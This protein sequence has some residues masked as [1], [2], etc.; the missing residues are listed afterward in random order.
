MELQ[1][2]VR[3]LIDFRKNSIPDLAKKSKTSISTINRVLNNDD[4]SEGTLLK[5]LKNLK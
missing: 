3:E 5:I 2:E 4:V 1:K